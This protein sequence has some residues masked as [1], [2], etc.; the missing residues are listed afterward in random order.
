MHSAAP[1]RTVVRPGIGRGFGSL[2][3]AIAYLM[4][5]PHLWLFA[6]V[7]ALIAC[8][9]VALALSAAIGW[10]QPW[11]LQALPK[12]ESWY[13][14][15]GT[16]LLSWVA[17]LLVGLMGLVAALALTPPLSAPALERLVTE[18]ET[19]LGIVPRTSI[20]FWNEMGCGVRAQVFAAIFALPL[21]CLLWFLELLVPV[22]SVVTVPLKFLVTALG[23]AWNLF[24]YPLTLRG[25]RMRDRFQLIKQHLRPCL[26]FGLAFAMLFWIPCLGTFLLPVG[27]IAATEVVWEILRSD[28]KLIPALPR[29]PSQP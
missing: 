18:R 3:R 6:L 21:L 20:G 24:D 15:F 27:V 12:S 13:G 11:V 10:L 22:L 26:G 1:T 29:V 14:R 19:E 25:V 5:R 9:L 7:P 17:T 23:L 4:K 2:F 16:E 8:V 28:S